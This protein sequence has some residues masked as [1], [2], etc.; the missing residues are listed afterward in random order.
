VTD[1]ASGRHLDLDVLAEVD[2]GIAGPEVQQAA[3]THLDGC[4]ACRE[5]MAHLRTTRALLSTLPAEAMPAAVQTRIAAAL[6]QAT[7]QPSGTVVPMNRRQRPWNS[8]AVA[9]AA[10]AA[11]VVVLLGAL[12]AGHVIHR[13]G[14]S[15]ST[16]SSPLGATSRPRAADGAG[17]KEWATGVNYTAATIPSLVPRLITGT[18]PPGA[19][20]HAPAGGSGADSAGGTFKGGSSGGTAGTPLSSKQAQVPTPAPVP[21]RV[22]T[23][24][25]MRT[26]PA[27]VAACGTI[28]AG[29]VPTVPVAVDFA[30]YDGKPAVIF[31]LP[32]VRSPAQ[33][34]VWVVRSTCSSSSLDLYF[35][36]IPRPTG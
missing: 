1:G 7:A 25:A 6:E 4:A 21:P 18:P 34:D 14:K 33:L 31:A 5:R 12:V 9:G 28:L 3:R 20:A 27:A 22:I 13:N 32:A 29:G 30:N 24:E 36:R 8:P 2:E 16:A 23:Q 10:A 15:S 35:R 19:T 17:I 26:S 11:A